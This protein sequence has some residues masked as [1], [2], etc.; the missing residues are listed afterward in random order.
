MKH[1]CI[2]IVAAL[3]A[4]LAFAQDAPNLVTSV[5]HGD[6]PTLRIMVDRDN[7]DTR[8]SSGLTLLMIAAELGDEEAVAILLEH[9]A[10]PELRDRL[11]FTA[12]D[13]LESI[14]R[15]TS[16]RISETERALKAQGLDEAQ[17]ARLLA[18]S[19]APNEPDPSKLGRMK[20]IALLLQEAQD[21]EHGQDD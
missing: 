16:D 11:G 10:R 14:F 6:I 9:G 12:L 17:V 4:L 13:R 21:A 5:Q 2:P 3:W 8:D 1:I 7:V 18:A 20:R 19:A 15:R